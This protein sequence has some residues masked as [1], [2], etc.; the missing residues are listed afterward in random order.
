M[1]CFALIDENKITVNMCKVRSET[2]DLGNNF[3]S[4]GKN[5][6]YFQIRENIHNSEKKFGNID[7]ILRLISM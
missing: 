5:L 3:R 1:L 6:D 4:K 2:D 7:V